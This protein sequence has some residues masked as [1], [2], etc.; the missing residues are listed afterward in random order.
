MKENTAGA[1]SVPPSA[2]S[3]RS[4]WSATRRSREATA[5][6]AATNR[7]YNEEA[8]VTPPPRA[9]PAAARTAAG[10]GAQESQEAIGPEERPRCGQPRRDLGQEIGQAR[11][12]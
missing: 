2:R 11:L 7:R 9:G 8:G 4:L 6:D 5:T 10:S 12:A 3:L 1:T